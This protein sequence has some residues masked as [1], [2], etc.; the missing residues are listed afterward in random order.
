[1]S[2]LIRNIVDI[3]EVLELLDAGKTYEQIGEDLG[4]NPKLLSAYMLRQGFRAR[5]KNPHVKDKN[6]IRETR[7]K[8]GMKQIE[9][10]ELMGISNEAVR[11]HEMN[12]KQPSP[13]NARKYASFL[14]LKT[15]YPKGAK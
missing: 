7:L 9:L 3:D 11:K 10:A 6:I 1:M 12:I 8:L 5:E 14:K 15:I 2:R 4:V 13:E